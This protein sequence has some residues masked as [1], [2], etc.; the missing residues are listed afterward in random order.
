MPFNKIFAWFIKKRMHQ[1]EL[2]RKHPIEVQNELLEKLI[3]EGRSTEYGKKYHFDSIQDREDFKNKVPLIDYEILKVWVDRAVKGEENLLWPG[4]TKWFA[5]SSGTTSDRS[6]FIPVTKESL[7]DCHYKGGK[8]LLAINYTLYP[9]SKVFNG[10]HLIIGGS[11][12]QNALRSDSYTG[13]LSSIIIKNLPWWVEFK[14]TPS[15]ETVLLSEWEEKLERLARETIHEDVYIISGVPSWTLVLLN[16]IL[17]IAG[18]ENLL[19]VWPNLELFMHG[20]VSFEPYRKEFQRI[21]PSENMHYLE[22]YNASEGFFGIQDQIDGDLL[23]MLDYG[24][25]FEFIPMSDFEGI[26]S[27]TTLNL[28]EVEIGVNYAVVISTNGGLWRYILGDTIVFTEKF[29][30]RFVVSGR[31][32]HFINTFGE[33]LIVNNSDTAIQIASEKNGALVKDYT[34][35]PVYMEGKKSG[36]HEWLIE[37]SVFPRDE[38]KFMEDIDEVLKEFNSDYAAKRT[39]NFTLSF[40]QL[41]IARTGLFE[42]WLKS[43]NKLGG[44]HK[45]P[46]LMNDRKLMEELLNF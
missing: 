39:N 26:N 23:L 6:K 19:D 38:R 3:Q 35:A 41:T 14:R 24:I 5:K 30:F 9:G 33:E 4:D 29:P 10:K 17:E 18:T 15:K 11:A 12:E 45:I 46:R 8:D 7:E 28:N 40:P 16:R 42:D 1:I 37:F 2:F 22:S 34:V 36:R 13:D 27:K 31:T 43:K 44:Q 25:F 20:G 21:I 32:K